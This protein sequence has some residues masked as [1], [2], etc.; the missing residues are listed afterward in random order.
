MT[1]FPHTFN[2]DVGSLDSSPI[3]RSTFLQDNQYENDVYEFDISGTRSI[4]LSLNNISAGDDAD[5]RLYRDSDNNS[6]LDT[7]DQLVTSSIRGSDADD[8][9]NYQASDGTY[10]ARVNCYTGGS[11]NRINYDLDLSA[12]PVSPLPANDPL[13]APNLLPN[14]IEIGD[15]SLGSAWLGDPNYDRTITRTGWVGDSDTAD[16][17]HFSAHSESDGVSI[18]MSLTGL[19]SDADIRLIQDKNFNQ[20]VDIEEVIASSNRGGISNDSFSIYLDNFDLANN[21]YFVQVY[22][23]SGDTSYDLNMTFQSTIG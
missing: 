1:Q 12:T 2:Y 22:Q 11:D 23:Y 18:E 15:I 6:V 20:I 13:Q 16:T 4:N 5:L 7:S 17:Y 14:E 8:S 10:F 9:I 3:Q 19:S 21:D